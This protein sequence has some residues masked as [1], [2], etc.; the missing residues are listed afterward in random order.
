VLSATCIVLVG[1]I[2]NHLVFKHALKVCVLLKTPEPIVIKPFHPKE[3]VEKGLR[4]CSADAQLGEVINIFLLPTILFIE[5]ILNLLYLV[6]G[7]L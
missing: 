2:K 6:E 7:G 1:V 4:R 3:G 5:C